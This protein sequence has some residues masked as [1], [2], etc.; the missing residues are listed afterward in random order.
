[1]ARKGRAYYE[2]VFST[3]ECFGK[4]KLHY[5]D[6]EMVEEIKERLSKGDYEEVKNEREEEAID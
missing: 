3:L 2:K 4:S 5:F 6:D 1:M